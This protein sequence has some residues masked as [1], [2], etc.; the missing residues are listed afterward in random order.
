MGRQG[1][2]SKCGSMGL[3][4]YMNVQFCLILGNVG[5]K[6]PAVVAPNSVRRGFAISNNGNFAVDG[7]ISRVNGLHPCTF[8]FRREPWL[9]IDLLEIYLIYRIDFRTCTDACCKYYDR[10]LPSIY[11][12]YTTPCHT[13]YTYTYWL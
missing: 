2:G 12:V 7:V 5:L 11:I 13:L 6:K 9:R 4:R 3:C 10:R 1:R 8:V